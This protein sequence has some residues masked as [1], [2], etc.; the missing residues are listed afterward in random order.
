M[1]KELKMN[2][3]QKYLQSLIKGK[4]PLAHPDMYN[5][6]YH[7]LGKLTPPTEEEVVDALNNDFRNP[8]KDW[9]YDKDL[10]CFWSDD[11]GDCEISKHYQS[12]ITIDNKVRLLIGRFYEG[13][14]E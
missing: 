9:Y 11:N 13:L 10:K 6:I 8:Y 12:S 14:D 2:D 5:A 3:Y 7:R 4:T 1:D